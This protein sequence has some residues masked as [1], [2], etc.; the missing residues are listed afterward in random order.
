MVLDGPR[1]RHRGAAGQ[2]ST[3]HDNDDDG[4]A[5]EIPTSIVDFMEFYLLHYFK[6]GTGEQSAGQPGGQAASCSGSAATSCHIQ[7]LTIDQATAASPTWRRRSTRPR[8][9]RSTASSPPPRCSSPPF[10]R[11]QRPPAHQEGRTW[12]R[13]WCATSSRTSSATTWARTSTSATTTA[14]SARRFLTTPLWGV[15]N[16]GPYGHDGRSMNLTDVI[17]RH[18]GE[19]QPPRDQF[20]NALVHRPAA[21]SS[22]FLEHAGAVPAGRHGLEPAAEGDRRRP[23]T[24]S[25]GTAAS[26]WGRSSTTR[27]TPSSGSPGRTEDEGGMRRLQAPHAAAV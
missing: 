16:T 4:V 25:S 23:A 6:A 26:G 9:T 5:N 3:S 1:R 8:A 22:T 10:R 15:G 7:D 21:A 2:D 19:A 14:P 20:A 13:S 27:T 11:R 17:L 12:R 18:G 24:R